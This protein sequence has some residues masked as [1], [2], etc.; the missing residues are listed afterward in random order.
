[1]ETLRIHAI[2]RNL[3]FRDSFVVR[4]YLLHVE[5][6]CVPVENGGTKEYLA[7]RNQR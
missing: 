4:A 1:M 6:C 5:Q 3:Y 2:A 7:L